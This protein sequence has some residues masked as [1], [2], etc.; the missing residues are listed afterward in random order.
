MQYVP[1][2]DENVQEGTFN[3][4][5][6]ETNEVITGM[7]REWVMNHFEQRVVESVV[8]DA[9]GQFCPLP[10]DHPEVKVPLDNRQVQKLRWVV[11]ADDLPGEKPKP[12]FEGIL[13][14]STTITLGED[15]V[16]KNFTQEYKDYVKEQGENKRL[17]FF[18]VPPGAP[19]T[20]DGHEMIDERMPELKYLQHDKKTCLFS[21]FASALHY[22]GLEKSAQYVQEKALEYSSHGKKGGV[23]IWKGL[24]D[25]MQETCSW[26]VPANVGTHFNVFQDLSL[27]PTAICLED[28][29]GSIQHAVTIVGALVFD[30]NC[31]RALPLNKKTLDYCCATKE[32]EGRFL[33]VIKGFRFSENENAKGKRIK[34]LK[35]QHGWNPYMLAKFGDDRKLII[36]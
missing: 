32:K 4:L 11:P 22:L 19:R 16:T 24:T 7:K 13:S 3:V 28:M 27:Y 26:L 1:L 21:S 12:H 36:E 35:K 8:H 23:D 31:Q 17:C 9:V 20:M 5:M 33:K 34:A 6:K 30:A 25:T 18:H 29:D 14:D 10:E 2:D 15:F